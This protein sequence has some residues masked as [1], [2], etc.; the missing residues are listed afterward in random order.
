MEDTGGGKNGRKGLQERKMEAGGRGERR[1]MRGTKRFICWG[2]RAQLLGPVGRL[3]T[4]GIQ[5]GTQEVLFVSPFN[6]WDRTCRSPLNFLK[7]PL[8]ILDRIRHKYNAGFLAESG[9]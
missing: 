7:G 3:N 4:V 1:D 2:V 5:S 9:L 8:T 6:W